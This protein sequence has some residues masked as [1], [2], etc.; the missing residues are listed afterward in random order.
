M[1]QHSSLPN[2]LCNSSDQYFNICI[3]YTK[4]ECGNSCKLLGKLEHQ[5]TVQTQRLISLGARHATLILSSL[6]DSVLQVHF[7]VV[8]LFTILESQVDRSYVPGMDTMLL[9][10]SVLLVVFLWLGQSRAKVFTFFLIN[11]KHTGIFAN[12]NIPG[13]DKFAH[14]LYR[15]NE[16]SDKKI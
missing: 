9:C 3:Q 11:P 13:E 1:H 5:C 16:C 8:C 15:D 7:D 4:R 2:S 14:Q 6:A 10:V 12:L